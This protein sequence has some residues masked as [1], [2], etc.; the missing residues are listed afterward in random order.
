MNRTIRDMSRQYLSSASLLLPIIRNPSHEQN[1]K[2]GL[3]A[4]PVLS[5]SAPAHYKEPFT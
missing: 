4:V 3:Q 5:I 2:G 1:C